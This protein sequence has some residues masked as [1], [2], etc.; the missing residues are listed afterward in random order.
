MK[1]N[2]LWVHHTSKGVFSNSI[3][4]EMEQGVRSPCPAAAPS[5]IPKYEFGFKALSSYPVESAHFLATARLSALLLGFQ[6]G[7]QSV[8]RESTW[9]S[10]IRR[11][12]KC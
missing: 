6:S 4:T 1:K 11:T 12:G 3:R 9:R 7:T 2:Y 5:A 8:V 10:G